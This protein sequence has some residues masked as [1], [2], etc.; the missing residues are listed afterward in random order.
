MS[1]YEDIPSDEQAEEQAEEQPTLQS[2]QN[3]DKLT[4]QQSLDIQTVQRMLENLKVSPE[5]MKMFE[6]LKK[7]K[8]LEDFRVVNVSVN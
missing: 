3:S 7:Y 2:E 5:T 1:D 6:I 8:R 4:D